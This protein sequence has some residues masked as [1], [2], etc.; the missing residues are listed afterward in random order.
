MR[1]TLTCRQ[2]RISCVDF[3]KCPSHIFSEVYYK[4]FFAPP[5]RK[6][7]NAVQ[8]RQ[9]VSSSK[10]QSKHKGFQ[11]DGHG[12]DARSPRLRK[13]SFNVEVRVKNIKP[14]PLRRRVLLLQEIMK[15]QARSKDLGFD[16]SDD[17][18]GEM[19]EEDEEDEDDE[20]DDDEEDGEG[21]MNAS[22]MMDVDWDGFG[23][24]TDGNGLDE[25]DEEDD[26]S[27]V[28]DGGRATIERLKDD[29]FAEDD[30]NGA[31]GAL[32][33]LIC[34]T[35][36]HTMSSGLS[37]HEKR[38]AELAA[39]INELEQENV[40]P[41]DWTLMGEVGSR[42]RPQNALLEQDLEYDRTMRPVPSVTAERVA[43]L[44]DMIKKRIIDVRPALDPS[45]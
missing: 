26:A 36:T 44:E 11:V 10:S 14:S 41:R 28:E 8:K 22:D 18:D 21:P 13:V 29:L 35:M 45:V 24:K 38:Q 34:Y 6:A 15:G 33:P 23:A 5:S 19:D 43:S 20:E 17:E 30:E 9:T 39:Q 32:T 3:G 4:D 1:R 12:A 7:Y 37:A 31:S 42:G 27:D 25:D 40:G 16:G 2:V